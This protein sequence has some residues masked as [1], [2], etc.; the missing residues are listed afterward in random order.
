[1]YAPEGCLPP[2][3]EPGGDGGPP[4][5]ASEAGVAGQHS[6]VASVL[7]NAANRLAGICVPN[8]G[9]PELPWAPDP[10]PPDAPVAAALNALSQAISTGG[11][12]TA[13]WLGGAFDWPPNP[14]SV[15]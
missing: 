3:P 14:C 5:A 2:Q 15:A 13:G 9:P 11:G 8:P 10:G 12:T 4:E 7:G 6:A 1:M